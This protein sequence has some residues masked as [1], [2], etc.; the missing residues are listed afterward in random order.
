MERR[1]LELPL[2]IGGATTSRQ[3]TA[4]RI[5]PAYAQRTVHVLDAS[6]VVGVVSNLLDPVRRGELDV[7]NRDEQERLRELH[8]EKE[9]RPLLPLAAARANREPLAFDDLADARVHGHA[10]RRAGARGAARRYIDWQFFFH[11]W[12]LKG[13]FPAILE[14]PAARELYDD[15]TAQL[16]EIVRDGLLQ[17]RGVY[18]FWP[19]HADG[20]DIVLE[21][22]RPLPDAAPAGRVG[23]LAPEPLPGRL[24]RRRPATTSARSP[25]RSTAPT[26]SRRATRPSTTTTAR[27][28]SRRSPTGSPR[29]SPSS[30]TE[31]RRAWYEPDAA[32]D[33]RGARR[34]ALP[35]DPAR[36]R[37]PGLPRPLREAAALRP[38]RRRGGRARAD[39]ELR[40]DA[41]RGRQRPLLRPPAVALLRRRPRSAATRSRTTPPA[42][43]SSVGEAERWLRPNL[44]YDPTKRRRRLSARRAVS[45]TAI[46]QP[47]SPSHRA[48]L[49]APLARHARAPASGR[50]SPRRA[51]RR[52][53]RPD[54]LRARGSAPS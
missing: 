9:R 7:E 4:V 29:R 26:S 21:Q 2:L 10:R 37:L 12:E 6:R 44:A 23:R 42:R 39:R 22:R 47:R 46:F 53:L 33:E 30:S 43:A 17:A 49:P 48:R 38:A 51:H 14:Q 54:G 36:V 35:R 50:T 52:R 28:W 3:H 20:D 41:G 15:A 19:A 31:A 24:R 34:R 25:S 45:V 11:A 16:D 32:P 13:K 27:S 5:A 8:A 1:G 40:D 18:G